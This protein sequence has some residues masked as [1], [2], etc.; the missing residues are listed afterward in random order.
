M[1]SLALKIRM[2]V[3][4]ARYTGNRIN[5]FIRLKPHV[6]L[7]FLRRHGRIFERTIAEHHVVVCIQ[8]FRVNCYRL[9]KFLNRFLVLAL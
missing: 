4:A 2:G 9:L 5:G 7:L 3:C 1:D 8:I 6:Q